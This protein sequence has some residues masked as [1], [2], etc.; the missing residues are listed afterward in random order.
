MKASCPRLFEVEALRDGRLSGV[1]LSRFQSH[2][3]VCAV[4]A[5][6]AA[7]LEALARRLRSEPRSAEGDELRVRRERTRLLAAFDAG[8]LPE[9]RRGVEK[10]WFAWTLASALLSLLGVLAW[11]LWLP[12]VA[13]VAQSPAEP[14]PGVSVR[15]ERSAQWSRRVE[16]QLETV[17]LQSGVL[18]I[19]VDRAVTQRRLLVVLPDGELEDVGTTFSVSAD[20]GRTTRVLVQDGSVVLR[21]RGKPALVL[22][23]GEAWSAASMPLEMPPPPDSAVAP[24]APPSA[25]PSSRGA[26]ASPASPIA[27]GTSAG[28]ANAGAAATTA[29]GSANPPATQVAPAAASAELT[30]STAFRA[31]MTAFNSGDNARAE[32]LFSHFLA[33]HPRDPH[34][35]DA[36]YLRILSLQRRGDGAGTRQAARDYLARFPRGFRHAEV[37]ALLR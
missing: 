21:L 17:V 8:L 10:P 26:R 24:P 6:E 15:A 2:L 11:A 18:A 35:E 7:A 16:G 37:D 28:R 19:H 14:P 36:A 23:A 13:P 31:A 25:L 9:P 1:E 32:A 4:C 3:G 30:S 12:R 22:G 34:A 5:A 27:S 33:Q 20:A 29:N